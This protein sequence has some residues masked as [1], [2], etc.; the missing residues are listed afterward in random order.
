MSGVILDESDLLAVVLVR[1]ELIDVTDI[2][3]AGEVD[4]PTLGVVDELPE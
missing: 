1:E 3:A 2:M 4:V